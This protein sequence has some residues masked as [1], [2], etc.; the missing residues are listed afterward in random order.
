M[1]NWVTNKIEVIGHNAYE[2]VKDFFN[3]EFSFNKIIPE[4]A[5][6][7]ECEEKY[8]L[9]NEEDARSHFLSWDESNERK[10]F[11]W[12]DW[13]R[14]KWGTKWDIDTNEL[15]VSDSSVCFYMA[16]SCPLPVI[17]ALSQKF[18]QFTFIICFEDEAMDYEGRFAFKN[19]EKL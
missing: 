10:W 9:N 7:E 5:T 14:D 2:F 4:P 8:I 11:N 18:P 15:S 13:R 6:P 17:V 16:W 1:P 12:Y 19:G 3:E